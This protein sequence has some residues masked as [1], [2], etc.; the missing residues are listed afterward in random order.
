M[1]P[2]V[3]LRQQIWCAAIL[4]VHGRI[5]DVHL[6][7]IALPDQPGA[8][9]TVASALGRA[10]GDIVSVDVVERQPG[11]QAVDD[12]LVELPLGGRADELVSAC[13]AVPGVRVLWLSR[14]AAGG[15]L[16]RDLEA[17][18]AMTAAPRD[19]ERVLVEL[20]P[21]VFRAH[22]AMLVS[23][24]RRDEGHGAKATSGHGSADRAG[25]DEARVEYASSGAPGLPDG[26]PAWTSWDQAARIDVPE[27]WEEHGWRHVAAAAVP[28]G[29]RKVLVLGRSGGPEILESEL[30]RLG[31]LAALARSI[32]ATGRKANERSPGRH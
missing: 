20:L 1:D 2:S 9:G 6:L 30:A 17:V 10:G 29:A 22:W 7:R 24:G 19:A 3:G 5:D 14:Y 12:F 16:H 18:E 26:P 23:R 32:G 8:L 4:C 31:H 21:E 27:E 25:T 15:G 13:Q 28:I 11:G